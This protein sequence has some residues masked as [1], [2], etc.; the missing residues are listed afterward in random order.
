MVGKNMEATMVTQEYLRYWYFY[1]DE[2]GF[3]YWRRSNKKKHAIRGA[4]VSGGGNNSPRLMTI[5]NNVY[6][7]H[8][9]I[10]LYVYGEYLKDHELIDHIDGD[11]R[12]NKLTNLRLVNKSQNAQNIK[13][14]PIHNR[15]GV[16]GATWSSQKGKY[17][18]CIVINGKKIY[19]GCFK[20]AQEAGAAYLAAK[21]KF[22]THNTL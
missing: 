15:S 9:I 20:E 11:K 18:S 21:R 12:N 5:N 16:L 8:R 14:A 17:I 4:K 1:N 22:H 10:W 13:K 7:Y 2:T 19:L 6:K 3:F